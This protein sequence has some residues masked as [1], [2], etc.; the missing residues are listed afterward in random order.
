MT[1]DV[2]T[3]RVLAMSG[4][5]SFES[6]QF[7]RASQAMRQPGSSFKPFV[8]LT[9]MEQG[10]SPS[11][12]FDDSA[13]SYGSW[14]PNN[15]EKDFWGATT[16]H[17]ALRE[18]R[19]LVTIR[20]AAHIGI[21]SVAKIIRNIVMNGLGAQPVGDDNLHVHAFRSEAGDALFVEVGA[22]IGVAE[23]SLFIRC[24]GFQT[25]ECQVGQARL[26][27]FGG[28][29]LTSDGEIGADRSIR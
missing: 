14:H 6:S 16:L 9:A 27:K 12:K 4:G 25:P 2:H 11:Q 3:G 15:Y 22:D 29:G 19:N 10:I 26:V 13:V 7:N 5:W 20:L 1:M 24:P 18:S 8:Y 23:M 17:D 21:K 28:D